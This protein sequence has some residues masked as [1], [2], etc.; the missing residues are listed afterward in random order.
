L[1]GFGFNDLEDSARDC[2][3]HTKCRQHTLEFRCQ[4]FQNALFAAL[5]LRRAAG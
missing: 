1:G 2:V 4:G 5:A 3:R